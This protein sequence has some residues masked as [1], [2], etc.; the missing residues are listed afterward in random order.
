M[1][2][3][4]FSFLNFSKQNVLNF[5]MVKLVVVNFVLLKVLV[6]LVLVNFSRLMVQVISK[7]K[8]RLIF[9][10]SLMSS[11]KLT[12]RKKTKILQNPTLLETGVIE[13][14]HF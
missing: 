8:L 4:S 3:F 5:L 9:S 10:I 7:W 6:K 1:K 13:E 11:M 12:K 2:P 14:S